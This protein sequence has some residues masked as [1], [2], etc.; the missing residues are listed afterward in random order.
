MKNV[1]DTELEILNALWDSG[2][3]TVRQIVEAVYDDHSQSLHTTVKSLLERLIVK[4]YVAGDRSQ[5]PH[6]FHATVDRAAYIQAQVSRL[7]GN[8]FDGH[9]APVLLSLVDSVKLSRKDRATLE[10]ILKKIK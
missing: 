9:M 10:E 4:E 2:P 1:S 8:V 3:L 6:R 5:S 7:A